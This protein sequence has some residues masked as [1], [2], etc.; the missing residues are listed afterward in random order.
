MK[1]KLL[2]L[3]SLSILLLIASCKKEGPQGPA[4]KDGN[5]NVVSSNT[6]VLSNWSSV[7]DDG[8]D[9]LYS[10]TV[11]WPTIT[12]DVK[13]RGVVMVYYHDNTTTNWTAVPYSE[14]GTGYSYSMNLDV[15]VGAVNISFEGYDNT[16][17]PG[18]SALNGLFTV[19][20]VAIPASARQANPNVNLKDYNAVKQAYHLND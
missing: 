8:T 19:R 2:P 20:L 18:A 16:G 6:V 3:A 7:Y 13:D 5:A 11:T 15:A 14:A 4:G 1:N 17:S 10:S 12:Q 9:F